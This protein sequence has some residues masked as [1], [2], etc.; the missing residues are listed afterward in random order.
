M[1]LIGKNIVTDAE[2]AEYIRLQSENHEQETEAQQKTVRNHFDARAIARVT[3]HPRHETVPDP[4]TGR[5]QLGIKDQRVR[6]YLSFPTTGD[7]LSLRVHP[8][9]R[10]GPPEDQPEPCQEKNQ[11]TTRRKTLDLSKGNSGCYVEKTRQSQIS[12]IKAKLWPKRKAGP[13]QDKGLAFTDLMNA[14]QTTAS[15]NE[16]MFKSRDRNRVMPST[17]A[18][19]HAP[20]EENSLKEQIYRLTGLL[21]SEQRIFYNKCHL[22]RDHSNLRDYGIGHGDTLLVMQPLQCSPIYKGERTKNKI[23]LREMSPLNK[24]AK[25]FRFMPRWQNNTRPRLF[26]AEASATLVPDAI[27]VFDYACIPDHGHTDHCAVIRRMHGIT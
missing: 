22:T 16:N 3:Q 18:H 25:C 21:P 14:V 4:R 19:R 10:L 13:S 20:E 8:E 26:E 6:I 5:R 1:V 2:L 12:K 15:A 27:S 11:E 17:M 24:P 23:N 7:A 9:L